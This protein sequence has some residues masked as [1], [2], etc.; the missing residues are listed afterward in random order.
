MAH[1]HVKHCQSEHHQGARD[2]EQKACQQAAGH[3]TELPSRIGRQLHGLRAGQQHAEAE[4]TEEPWLIEP[5]LLLHQ[6]A[7]HERDLRRRTA[8]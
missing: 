6:N 8:E 2:H 5:P 7:V 3:T 4:R 1:G